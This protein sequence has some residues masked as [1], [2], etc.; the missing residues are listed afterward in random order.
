MY[1]C[2]KNY[3]LFNVGGGGIMLVLEN[4]EYL[5]CS[6]YFW[7]SVKF[8]F[9]RFVVGDIENR[10]WLVVWRVLFIFE[11]NLRIL[12]LFNL[13]FGDSFDVLNFWWIF[14]I[15]ILGWFLLVVG[16]FLNICIC[17]FM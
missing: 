16:K 13:R 2:L 4:F 11:V 5:K 7:S 17:V 6:W 9:N 8:I 15:W 1:K 10:Y 14:E 12:N 3:I